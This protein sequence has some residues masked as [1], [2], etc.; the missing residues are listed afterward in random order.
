VYKIT[1]LLCLAYLRNDEQDTAGRMKKIYEF[2]YACVYIYIYIYMYVYAGRVSFPHIAVNIPRNTKHCSG[3]YL[4]ELSE[5]RAVVVSQGFCISKG[6]QD[7]VG[8]W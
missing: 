1:P 4:D 8:L 6:L 3:T 5:A 7:R 2:V